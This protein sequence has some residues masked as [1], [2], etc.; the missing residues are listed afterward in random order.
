MSLSWPIVRV[1]VLSMKTYLSQRFDGLT[2]L[3]Q[4][5]PNLA[6]RESAE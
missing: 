2:A 6:A 5:L 4:E 1:P 3:D